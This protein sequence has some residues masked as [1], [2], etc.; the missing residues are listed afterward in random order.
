MEGTF[1]EGLP[2]IPETLEGLRKHK[3]RIDEHHVM[4]FYYKIASSYFGLNVKEYPQSWFKNIKLAAIVAA[5][6][7][8]G[9]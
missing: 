8:H 2:L 1:K 7:V 5:I 6:F 9:S 3:S 4:V